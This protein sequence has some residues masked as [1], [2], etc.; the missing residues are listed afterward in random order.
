[1]SEEQDVNPRDREL[2]ETM[3]ALQLAPTQTSLHEVWYRAGFESGRR[4]GNLWRAAAMIAFVACGALSLGR[5]SNP[6]ATERI[7]YV[8]EQAPRLPNSPSIVAP[9]SLIENSQYERLC[10]KVA[11]LGLDGLPP[12]R[13]WSDGSPPARPDTSDPDLMNFNDW[14]LPIHG[15]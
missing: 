5:A 15:G 8:R 9:P 4:K 12:D 6:A 2:I 10:E 3:E 13:N 14:R 11:M 7:V 1:M